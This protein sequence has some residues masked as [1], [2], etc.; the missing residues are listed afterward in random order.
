MVTREFDR[1]KF[2]V[3]FLKT[4]QTQEEFARRVGLSQ[5]CISSY[6]RGAVTPPLH[7]IVQLANGLHVD[8]DDLVTEAGEA[9]PTI[10]AKKP[11][12][13]YTEEQK[14]EVAFESLMTAIELI[15]IARDMLGDIRKGRNNEAI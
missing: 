14:E 12:E 13:K 2:R 8:V 9:T 11:T 1:D 15:K 6:F 3:L 5:A 7:R 10:E 4:G